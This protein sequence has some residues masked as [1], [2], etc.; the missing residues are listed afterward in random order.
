MKNHSKKRG[1]T[2]I[3]LLVVSTIIAIL[4]AIGMV[5]FSAAGRSARDGKRKS[6]METVR[7]ALTLYRQQNTGYP[8]GSSFTNMVSALS[9]AGYISQPLPVDPQTTNPYQYWYSSAG[10]TFCVCGKVENNVGNYSSQGCPGSSGADFYCV[11]S[12]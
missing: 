10:T 5:S 3:E 9:T 12:L 11:G 8:I 2:I 6:D 7:Q 1:F 4:A